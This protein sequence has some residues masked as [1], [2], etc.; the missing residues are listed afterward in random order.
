ML[1]YTFNRLQL[2]M[3]ARQTRDDGFYDYHHGNLYL[4]S[5]AV[6]SSVSE[7][8]KMSRA[9]LRKQCVFSM[10]AAYKESDDKKTISIEKLGEGHGFMA[11]EKYIDHT[12]RSVPIYDWFY[13]PKGNGG[14][15]HQLSEEYARFLYDEEDYAN[16][17]NRY[18]M[19]YLKRDYND[20]ATHRMWSSRNEQWSVGGMIIDMGE[21]IEVEKFVCRAYTSWSNSQ[22]FRIQAAR[23][24]RV[25]DHRQYDDTFDITQTKRYDTLQINDPDNLPASL[26]PWF[27]NYKIRK[28]Q[29]LYRW[30]TSDTS[31]ASWKV[32]PF[33]GSFNWYNASGFTHQAR[34]AQTE[35][36]LDESSYTA[37]MQGKAR[38]FHIVWNGS[39]NTKWYWRPTQLYAVVK[40]TSMPPKDT[41]SQ[42]ITWAVYCSDRRYLGG[43]ETTRGNH[44]LDPDHD[45]MMFDV[46]EPSTDD[47]SAGIVLSRARGVTEENY[48]DI[49]ILQSSFELGWLDT[50]AT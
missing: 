38:Y 27:K 28:G 39:S 23:D 14:S 9:D 42:D 25:P 32:A 33:M 31:G 4:M 10:C 15:T 47:G 6:P 35:F 2:L 49:D 48:R 36:V 3:R 20:Q 12:E 29:F 30:G 11:H 8:N 26:V 34:H 17:F 37:S 40:D 45:I 22:M 13:A 18:D 41:S 50:E 1:V 46:A 19:F 5:G 43:Y 24:N 7:L 16:N 21:E 44:P